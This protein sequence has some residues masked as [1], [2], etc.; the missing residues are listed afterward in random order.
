MPLYTYRCSKCKAEVEELQKFDDPPPP[1]CPEC[2]EK[3]SLERTLGV[4]N[5]QLKGSG[6]AKDGYS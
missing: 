5:F 4:S 3:D 1:E 2:K 6:W